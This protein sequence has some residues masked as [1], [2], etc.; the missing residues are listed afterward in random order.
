VAAAY[1]TV[2]GTLSRSGGRGFGIAL[3]GTFLATGE[4]F[5]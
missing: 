2:E 1:H 3:L 4:F 5:P